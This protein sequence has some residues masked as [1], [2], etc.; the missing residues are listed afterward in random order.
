MKPKY[1]HVQK[2]GVW[3]YLCVLFLVVLVLSVVI[4]LIL[5]LKGEDLFEGDKIVAVVTWTSYVLA[6]LAVG[7]ATLVLSRLTVG[8]DDSYIRIQFGPGV[9]QKKFCLGEIDDCQQVRNGWWW[10]WGIRWYFRGWL[11]NI[12]GLDVVDITFKNNKKIRI[13]TDEPD[14]LAE[15][16]RQAIKTE[17]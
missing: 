16:I 17:A 15:A 3:F 6:F 7:W 10:G 12:D 14:K 5:T 1:E 4:M 9:F 8:I 11:Y 2:G 13:G